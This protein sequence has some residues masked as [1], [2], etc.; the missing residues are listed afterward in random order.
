MSRIVT[1]GKL[2]F[3][4]PD[5]TKKH[6]KQSTWKRTGMVLM[7]DDTCGL[8]SWFIEKRYNL[9]LNPPIRQAHFT[10]INDKLDATEFTQMA[11]FFEGKEIEFEYDTDVRTN[12]E[13]WWL[14]VWSDD[15]MNVRRAFG[16]EKPYWGFHITVGYPNEKK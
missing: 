3:D 5:L 6:N 10:V 14:K 13:Y 15:A 9:K 4:L 16:L 8:Y 7:R 11:K 12:G 2:T 1:K